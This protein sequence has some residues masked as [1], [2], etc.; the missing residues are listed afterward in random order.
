MVQLLD[1]GLS[2]HLETLGATFGEDPLWSA[3]LLLS[4]E[5]R[6]LIQKAHEEYI[7]AGC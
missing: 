7:E 6:Q 3:R 4:E 1:G 5:G 2:T